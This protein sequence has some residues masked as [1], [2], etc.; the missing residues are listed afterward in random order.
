MDGS[1]SE[2]YGTLKEMA[3]FNHERSWDRQ[4]H[5]GEHSMI[6]SLRY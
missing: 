1:L 2:V 6:E 4:P 3:S 5:A